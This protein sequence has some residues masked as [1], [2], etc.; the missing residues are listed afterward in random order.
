[1]KVGCLASGN[2]LCCKDPPRHSGARRFAAEESL[3]LPV[4]SPREIPRQEHRNAKSTLRFAAF[5][6]TAQGEQNDECELVSADGYT[7]RRIA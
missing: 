4:L 1:M 3:F 7:V 5:A 2:Q 6:R